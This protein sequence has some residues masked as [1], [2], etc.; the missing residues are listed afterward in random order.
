MVGVDES[1][2]DDAVPSV[3]EVDPALVE[4]GTYLFDPTVTA[5]D[6]APRELS[7]AGPYEPGATH[8]ESVHGARGYDRYDGR[9]LTERE[10]QRRLA[11]LRRPEVAERVGPRSLLL[12]PV[13]SVEQHG[14]HLP[15]DTDLVVPERVAGELAARSGDELDLW[16]LPSLAYSKSNEH[17]WAPGTLWLSART[18][19]AVLDDIGRSVAALPARALVFLNGH[20]GNS[21]LLSVACRDLHLDHGLATFLLHP[22]VPPDQGGPSAEAEEGMG[23]HGGFAETSLMMFLD[24]E[25]VASPL[26]PPRIPASLRPNRRVRFGGSATFGWSSEDFGPDGYVGD[27]T[28]ASA[29]AGREIFETALSALTETLREI[30]STVLA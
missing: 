13:G 19:L 2:G 3:E 5:D 24:P 30:R 20:G 18:L 10:N 15:L 12:L 4:G 22:M 27:P 11:R 16:V 23:V 26:P 21:A 14:P 6:V 29:E 25:R 17:A 7:C 28:G 8:E 9:V 1:G